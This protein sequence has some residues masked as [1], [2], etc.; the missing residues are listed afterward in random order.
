MNR[1]VTVIVLGVCLATGPALLDAAQERARPEITQ[2]VPEA[3]APSNTSQSLVVNGRNF[4]S[5]L[6][7]SITTPS[8]ATADYR[9]NAIT[10]LRD[11]MFRVSVM[12]SAP[13]TYRLVVLNPDAQSSAPFALNVRARA[14]GPVVREI[15]PIGLRVST[16]PQNLTIEGARFDGGLSVTVTDPAGNVQTYSGDAVRNLTPTSF[17]LVLALE[18]AGRHELIVTNPG[19]QVSNAVGFDVGR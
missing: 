16:S 17:Q 11:T 7:L 5:G 2:V 18:T 19:G 13:G 14:D 10:E 1:L 15:K 6:S 12:F 4:A 9:G 3:P 8:G